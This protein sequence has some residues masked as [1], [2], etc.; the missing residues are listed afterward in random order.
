MEKVSSQQVEQIK[1]MSDE[2]LREKLIAAGRDE[3]A[4]KAMDRQALMGAYAEL[5]SAGPVHRV[6]RA[7]LAYDL[8]LERER[9][10][11][12]RERWQAEFQ[13]KQMELQMRQLPRWRSD[14]GV[15]W[16]NNRGDSWN[17]SG[18]RRNWRLGKPS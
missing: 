2:R 16:K 11:F 17:C 18:S 13:M 14:N 12:E 5:V 1:K 9:L 3:N 15:R 10:S 4:V 7:A 6:A 8:E